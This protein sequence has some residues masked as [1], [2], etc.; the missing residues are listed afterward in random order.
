MDSEGRDC[1]GGLEGLWTKEAFVMDGP[2]REDGED[3]ANS[4]G[5]LLEE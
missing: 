5:P 2:G 4:D 1:S 3:F